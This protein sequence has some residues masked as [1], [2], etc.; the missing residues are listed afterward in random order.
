[1]ARSRTMVARIVEPP[2]MGVARREKA[3]CAGKAWIVL[4]RQE[5]LGGCFVKLPFEEI[6]RAD[7]G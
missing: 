5:Q 4:N 1:M 2:Y 6:G 3:V 7:R